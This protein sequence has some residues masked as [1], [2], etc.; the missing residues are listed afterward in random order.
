[1]NLQ[2][3]N[4]EKFP[5]YEIN[6]NFNEEQQSKEKEEKSNS[7]KNSYLIRRQRYNSDFGFK[8]KQSI[9][10][11]EQKKKMMENSL[12]L[13]SIITELTDYK[14]EKYKWIDVSKDNNLYNIT[15]LAQYLDLLP[16]YFCYNCSLIYYSETKNDGKK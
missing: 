13:F 1:M 4:T 14:I 12:K 2:R 15:K 3:K 11:S 10:F 9:I 8:Y 7:K 16:V 5:I 6:N